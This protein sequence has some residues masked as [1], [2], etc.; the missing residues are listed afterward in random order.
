MNVTEVTL[1][2]GKKILAET[3][4]RD[5]D[6]TRGM[7]FRDALPEGRGMISIYPDEAQHQI[8][9]FQCRI[10]LDVIWMDRERRI[11]EISADVPPCNAKSA[12]ACPTYGGRQKSKY[13]L[14]LSGG[15]AAANGLRMGDVLSF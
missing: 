5:I 10:P 15:R 9:T 7:M 2:N 13:I 14:E 12:R 4:I 11:V 1:P 6:L 8:W 3:M